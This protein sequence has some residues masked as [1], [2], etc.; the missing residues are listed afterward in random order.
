[1]GGQVDRF[2]VS[3]CTLSSD[4]L[5]T[6]CVGLQQDET[7]SLCHLSQTSQETSAE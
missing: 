2:Q 1:M 3:K 6:H 4:L 5:V 7:F